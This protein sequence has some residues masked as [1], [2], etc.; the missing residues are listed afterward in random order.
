MN[1]HDSGAKR[2][3]PS[4]AGPRGES[5]GSNSLSIVPF[6]GGNGQPLESN[7]ACPTKRRGGQPGPRRATI[8]FRDELARIIEEQQPCIVRQAYY[9]AIV[10]ELVSKAEAGYDK[11]QRELLAMRR[12][13][14]VPYEWVVDLGRQPHGSVGFDDPDDFINSVKYM[15]RRNY[16]KDCPF[17][18]EF[19]CEKKTLMSTMKPILQDKWGLQFYAGGGFTSESTLFAAGEE[20]AEIDKPTYVY[21][22][23]DWDV[24]GDGIADHIAHGGKKCPGGLPG[25]AP[26]VEVHVHKLALT[27][28]QVLEW[29]LITR[30]VKHRKGSTPGKPDKKAVEWIAKYGN[31]AAE[32]DAVR[33]N[34][35]RGLFDETIASHRDYAEVEALKEIGA[36]ERDDLAKWLRIG[37]RRSSS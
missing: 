29:D 27:H 23:S 8:K 30:E 18:L 31:N 20:I 25:F 37:R 34:T 9:Q 16:W 12:S 13:G 33:P 11:V 15:Y 24:S 14:Q 22:V 28:E 17:R 35:L 36:K 26:E 4:P 21:V 1:R 10:H 7:P 32:L 3:P 6:R 2:K 5:E 19:W